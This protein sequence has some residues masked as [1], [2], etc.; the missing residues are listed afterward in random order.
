MRNRNCALGA[1]IDFSSVKRERAGL[2]LETSI[3]AVG[4]DGHW[5]SQVFQD[6]G[7]LE[8]DRSKTVVEL[9][10]EAAPKVLERVELTGPARIVASPG[11][12][13]TNGNVE[14]I[15]DVQSA[16]RAGLGPRTRRLCGGSSY[17]VQ[18]PRGEQED[19][20]EVI[21]SARWL[22]GRFFL[23]CASEVSVAGREIERKQE[24]LRPIEKP[25]WHIVMLHQAQPIKECP[26]IPGGCPAPVSGSREPCSLRRRCL[27]RSGRCPARA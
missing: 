8:L 2:R 20:P 13:R 11:Q 22:G 12:G 15:W 16:S 5:F 6:L 25:S 21:R 10:A 18:A 4:A 27:S 14:A 24:I 23:V 9:G 26:M 7:I 19:L 17:F 3:E 1:A